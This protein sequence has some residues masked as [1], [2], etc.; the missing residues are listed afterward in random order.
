MNFFILC[1]IFLYFLESKEKF[2]LPVICNKN[3]YILFLFKINNIFSIFL[4]KKFIF[5]T[6]FIFF[7]K[8]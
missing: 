6:K 1:P 2:A 3:K 8:F 7:R 5:F 4:R